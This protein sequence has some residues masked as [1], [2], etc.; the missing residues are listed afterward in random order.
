[1]ENP[2]KEKGLLAR[3]RAIEVWA[4][5]SWWQGARISKWTI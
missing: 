2:E 4:I 5:D 3:K 1:M